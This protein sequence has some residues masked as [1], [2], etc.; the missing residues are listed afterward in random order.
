[1]DQDGLGRVA[2][3]LGVAHASHTEYAWLGPEG[4]RCYASFRAAGRLARGTR[5][6]LSEKSVRRRRDGGAGDGEQE[7]PH[8]FI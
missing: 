2:G 3:R 5:A 4:P 7:A 8:R 6:R 1:M